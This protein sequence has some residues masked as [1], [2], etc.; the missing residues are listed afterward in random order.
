M[1]VVVLLLCAGFIFNASAQ[2]PEEAPVEEVQL[3]Q[4]TE[5]L[6]VWLDGYLA[7]AIEGQRASGIAAVVIQDGEVILEQGYGFADAAEEVPVD[8]NTTLFSI[9]SVS[10]NFTATAIAQ[11]VERGSIASF[12][13]PANDYLARFA[14]EDAGGHPVTILHMLTHRSGLADSIYGLATRREVAAPISAEEVAVRVP[15]QMRPSGEAVIYSNAAFGLL[16]MMLEDVSG[17]TLPEHLEANIFEP[18]GMEHSFVRTSPTIPSGY[19]DPG[20]Y[21]S[22]GSRETIAQDWAYHPFIAPSAGVV[23]TARDLARFAQAH[24]DAEAGLLPDFLGADMA[25]YMHSRLSGNH[26]AVSGFG[27]S[28]VVHE[29]QGSRVF[30]N[31]GSGP[32]FQATMIIVPDLD[33][34]LVVMIAGGR[35]S[36]PDIEGS[37]GTLHMFEVREAF[38]RRIL[39]REGPETVDEM[40]GADLSQYVGTFRGERRPHGTVESV[41][42]PGPFIEVTIGADGTLTINGEAGYH[43]IAPNVFWKDGIAPLVSSAGSAGLYAFLVD[44]AGDVYGVTPGLSVDIFERVGWPVSTIILFG[45][46]SLGIT[47]IGIGGIFWRGKSGATRWASRL[48][49]AL[50]LAAA[51][52][53]SSIAIPLLTGVDIVMQIATRDMTVF[54]IIAAF[55]NLIAL[56]AIA[57]FGLT[58]IGWRERFVGEPAQRM[59]GQIHISLVAFAGLASLPVL[60]YFNLIGV[61]LP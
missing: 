22:D 21:A 39:G 25:R 59:L 43:Q 19:A 8:P 37:L 41:L 9:G 14:L 38:L 32:G 30:E 51:A 35:T 45:L 2:L 5:D 44:D 6:P 47:I 28:F 31:G 48:S 3:N 20:Q 7:D 50:G 55:A 46:I 11:L 60:N 26:P 52:L 13:D 15:V 61:H 27:L 4:T 16:G 18:L 58:I 1:L 49:L 10:K 53:F 54:I 12:E 29:R 40:A 17:N 56:L 23:S 33:I 34:V 42:N 36:D 57:L 24:L